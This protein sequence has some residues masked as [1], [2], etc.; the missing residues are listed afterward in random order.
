MRD[1]ETRKLRICCREKSVLGGLWGG[2]PG[3]HW[4]ALE[5]SVCI[6]AKFWVTFPTHFLELPGNRRKKASGDSPPPPAP[7]LAHPPGSCVSFIT[8]WAPQD[9]LS[10]SEKRAWTTALPTIR[11]VTELNEPMK[12]RCFLIQ[13]ALCKYK[14]D[15]EGF[16]FFCLFFFFFFF[17]TYR[18]TSVYNVLLGKCD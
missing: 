15:L 11:A 8:R 18:G 3:G 5:S 1:S 14:M 6:I 17:S 7:P 16:L 9:S 2:V 10:L 4:K 13:K 12:V